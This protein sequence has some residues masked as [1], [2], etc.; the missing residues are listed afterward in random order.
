MPYRYVSPWK[1]MPFVKLL[2]PL[3]A[4][5]I[6]KWYLPL[7]L[8]VWL[9]ILAASS[10]LFILFF[11]LPL[12]HLYRMV[13]V[14]GLIAVIMFIACGA[15]LAFH[16]D[17]RNNNLWFGKKQFIDSY[18]RVTL[19][20]NPVEK[21][22]SFKA[23]TAVNAIVANDQQYPSAGNV[24]VYFSK[25]SFPPQ[26]SDGTQ[27]VFSK[28]LQEI[29][30]AGNPG[31][32]DYKRYCLFQ[33]ITH[34]VYLRP[35]DYI[36]LNDRN[37][38]MLSGF[39]NAIRKKT[40][41]ILRT[42]I[43]GEKERG[44]A[45]ALLIGY[46]DDLDKTLVQSYSNTGVVHII[47]ISGLHLGLIYWLL[48][49]LLK[50]LQRKKHTRWLKPVIIIGG[51]WLFSLLAGAQPS[52]LRSA[53]MFTCIVL[54]ESLG[55]KSSIY[56]SLAASA[57]M[58]LCYNPYWLWDVG[59]QLSYTAVLSI[60]IFM[61]PIYNWFYIKNKVLD[62]TWKMN[63]VTLAAQVLTVPLSIYHF[64]QFPNYFLLTNLVAVPVSSVIVLG[65]ILLCVVSFIAP[66]ATAVGN[67]LHYLIWFMNSWIQRIEALPFSLWDGLQISMLQTILLVAATCFLSYW[68]LEKKKQGLIT[69][70]FVF[71]C[72]I[73]LRAVSFIIARQQEKIIVYNVPRFKAVDFI[74]GRKYQF[75]GDSAL[76]T[77][78][79]ARNFHL[80]PSRTLYRVEKEKSN[81][82]ENISGFFSYNNMNILMIDSTIRMNKSE[83]KRIIDLL[84]ISKNPKLYISN[85]ADHF[86]IKQ[87]VFDSSVPAWKCKYW[88]KDC[89]SLNI[90]NYDVTDKGA[91]V[92]NLR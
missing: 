53:V 89:D 7:A 83:D 31:G 87:V 66:V 55:R 60:V 14:N 42:H 72:F 62:F 91:F 13:T 38:S 56:N 21:A 84:I 78:D 18:Y 22:R 90:P 2:I 86:I 69:G 67:I 32:F 76:E 46:K 61:K 36:V 73:S 81:D 50:P 82:N 41:S 77:D 16:H 20:E 75:A 10:S 88:K 80:K 74:N 52:V 26:I 57:F 34:Q 40:L 8:S 64:H 59:F 11:F 30:N 15:I 45:E 1:K 47:A 65:E 68:L 28:S 24:I 71:L 49:Q 54:G 79:F 4:G 19:K 43:P 39:I 23:N 37:A 85:L 6:I 35:G 29:K 58:L 33:Q 51:L 17:I 48:I 70:L 3:A 63:A 27:I 9:V 92:M 5:I 44:L 12:H 25:D